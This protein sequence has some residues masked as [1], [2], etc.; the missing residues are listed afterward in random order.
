MVVHF[1]GINKYFGA[2][3]QKR[4][5][6]AFQDMIR[7]SFFYSGKYEQTNQSGHI[8][9]EDESIY[10]PQLAVPITHGQELSRASNSS[11]CALS[12]L[13]AQSQDLPRH[14]VSSLISQGISSQQ[15]VDVQVSETPFGVS[16]VDNCVPNESFSC[17]INSMEVTK[18]GSVMLFDAGQA[19]QLKVHGDDICQ[20]SDSLNVNKYCPSPEHGATV[21]LFQLSSHLQRVEQQRNSF[22]VKCE[23]EDSCFFSIE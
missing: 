21:D 3:F 18:N 15:P 11:S 23:N 8:K 7:S 16:S 17:G 10:R 4:P 6:F 22:P 2:S 20:P 9:F 13:S 19:L 14:S 1:P 5:Q 12:L